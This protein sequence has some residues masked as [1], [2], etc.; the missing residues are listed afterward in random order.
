MSWIPT[1]LKKERASRKYIDLV[2]SATD[3]YA[4]WEPSLP[5]VPGDYGL[6]DRRSGQ[7]EKHGNI[8]Q[9][10]D[11]KDLTLKYPPETG[12]EVDDYRIHSTNTRTVTLGPDVHATFLGA[13]Q[14]ALGGQW[15]FG[16]HRGALLL[17]YRQRI[18]RV[19]HELLEQLRISDW[20]KGRHIV[21]QVHNCPAYALYLSDRSSETVS[22]SLRVDV[23]VPT[24]PGLT[25]GAG[26]TASWVAKGV[27]GIFQ[28]ASNSEAV[29]APLYQLKEVGR[30]AGRRQQ[31][32]GA[33]EDETE[34]T[35]EWQLVEAPWNFL[36]ED[37]EEET[38]ELP[39]Q[40]D[41]E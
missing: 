32:P 14:P 12:P 35:E 40:S 29:F 18:T 3:K 5:I 6:V 24:V 4:S 34:L 38:R 31:A 25:A 8:Y 28:R 1:L 10:E 37:G 41:D 30:R 13:V 16:R 19:P 22:I 26:L 15:R 36:D 27:T 2:K 23:P 33:N 20:V 9:E 7:F 17:M 11:I 39:N 21:T